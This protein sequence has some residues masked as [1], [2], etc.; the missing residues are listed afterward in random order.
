MNQCDNFPASS[1]VS[2]CESAINCTNQPWCE[3]TVRNAAPESV[4]VG[5]EPVLKVRKVVSYPPTP[6]VG[7]GVL[8]DN[9]SPE[10]E[11]CAR[12]PCMT[13]CFDTASGATT[14]CDWK[15]N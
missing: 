13:C 8:Q 7:S 6:D 2:M 9:V 10:I 12:D 3:S 1:S 11:L 5:H 4:F 14:G 15:D